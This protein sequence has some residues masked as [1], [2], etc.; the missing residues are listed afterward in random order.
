[1]ASTTVNGIHLH[2]ELRGS[3]PTLV[4]L[5]GLQGDSSTFGN[6]PALLAR[7][8]TVLTYDQRGSGY[9]D[10][11]AM[12]YTTALLA[13]DTTALLQQL[14]FGSAAV[15]GTSMGGQVAQQLALRH[16]QRV[17]RLVLGCTTPGGRQAYPVHQEALESAYTLEPLSPAER[18]RRLAKVAFSRQW[19]AAHPA[20]VERLAQARLERPLDLGTLHRRLQAFRAHD[21][22]RALNR[23]QMPTMVLTGAPD[24]LIPDANSRLLAERIP[25]ARL[26][27]LEPAGHLFWIEREADTIA[28]LEG[29]LLDDDS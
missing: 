27:V 16:P 2:Y 12:P 29:F 28:E 4:L 6:L 21:T 22:S 11:P 3:G 18:A 15:F 14:G 20:V 1:M 7:R 13:D 17:L 23:I 9:S 5:H 24:G 8:F 26:R 25:G 10:K 19:L